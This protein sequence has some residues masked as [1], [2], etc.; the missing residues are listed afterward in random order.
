MR[1]DKGDTLRIRAKVKASGRPPNRQF[2]Y[3]KPY[4]PLRAQTKHEGV[5]VADRRHPGRSAVAA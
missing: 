2:G 1:R 4:E 5:M 3:K